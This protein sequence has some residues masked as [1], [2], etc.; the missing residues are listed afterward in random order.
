MMRTL[1]FGMLVAFGLVGC[2]DE[3][4]AVP[5]SESA[6]EVSI[7]YTVRGQFVRSVYDG[8]AAVFDHE[9]VPDVMPAMQIEM[10]VADPDL[11]A[12]IQPGDKVRFRLEDAGR[13][14]VITALERL[15]AD[16]LLQLAGTGR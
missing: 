11:L 7:R 9:A 4:A 10:R 1:L 12:T 15:S 14:L 3:P 16:A 8:Q 6:N 2:T 13:G 5:A